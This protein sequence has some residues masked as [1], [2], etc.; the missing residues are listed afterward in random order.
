MRESR[1]RYWP[2][3]HSCTGSARRLRHY[4]TAIGITGGTSA[5]LPLAALNESDDIA[6]KFRLDELRAV[7]QGA[8]ANRRNVTVHQQMQ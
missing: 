7:D 1:R 5:L 6:A 2:T 3:P 8:M 4:V